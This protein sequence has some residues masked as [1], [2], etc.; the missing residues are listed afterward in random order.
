MADVERQAEEMPWGAPE[1]VARR[2]VEA[3][4]SA[5]ADTVQISLN[6]G[7]LPHEMFI[8][9]IRRFARDVLP[10]LQAHTV[11]RVPLAEPVPA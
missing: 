3:A 7:V 4:D 10:A 1:E 5:G 2:I 6:R 8:E 9:Q 11:A